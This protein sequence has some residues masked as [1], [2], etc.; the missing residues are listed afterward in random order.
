MALCRVGVY[1]CAAAAVSSAMGI[2]VVFGATVLMAYMIGLSYVAKQE[3]FTEIQNLWPPL[4][5]ATPFVY[6]AGALRRVDSETFIYVFFLGWVIYALS[7][8]LKK[9]KEHSRRRCESHCWYL[10]V[11][12]TTYCHGSA[13]KCL[14]L[15]GNC[16]FFRDHCFPALRARHIAGC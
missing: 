13:A 10:I 7:H 8:L 11:G 9:T 16:R 2:R 5:L 12:R 6:A 15:G 14:G 1:F 3:N 4:L